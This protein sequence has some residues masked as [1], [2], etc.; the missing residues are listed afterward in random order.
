[1]RWLPEYGVALIGMANRTYTGWGGVFNQALEVMQK[2][3]ALR[4]RVP[5][6]SAALVQ[7]RSDVTKLILQWDDALANRIAA[8]NLFLDRS[9][10]R[11][12]REFDDLQAKVGACRP[13]DTFTFVENALRGTWTLACEKGHLDVAVTLAPTMPP[14]VQYLE[15]E[16]ARPRS[17]AS[18]TP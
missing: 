7:A 17:R 15:V 13:S 1:M 18:C 2:T 4:P 14:T 9:K 11:R 16:P 3:G 12:R 6:P 10:D 5:E 8:V